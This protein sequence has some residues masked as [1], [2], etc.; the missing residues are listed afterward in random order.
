LVN[1]FRPLSLLVAA[2]SS[3]FLSDIF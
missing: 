1:T 3:G 2:L